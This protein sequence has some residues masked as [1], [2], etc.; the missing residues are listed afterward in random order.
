MD[1]AD[2]LAIC[3]VDGLEGRASFALDEL[4]VDEESKRL[5]IGYAVWEIKFLC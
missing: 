3:G 1:G 5:L 2:G 4:P